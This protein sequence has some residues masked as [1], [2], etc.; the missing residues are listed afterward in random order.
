MGQCNAHAVCLTPLHCDENK[1]HQEQ[2]E[3]GSK[4]EWEYQYQVENLAVAVLACSE[5]E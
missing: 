3:K 1:L 2:P 5:Q 4:E